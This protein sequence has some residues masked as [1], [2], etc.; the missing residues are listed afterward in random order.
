MNEQTRRTQEERRDESEQRML[1]AGIRLVAEFGPEKLTLTEVG[2]SAGYSR[3]LPA[4]H[5]GSREQYLKALASHVAIEFDRTLS[6][7]DGVTGL[8]AVLDITRAVVAQLEADPT[9]GLATR[10]VLADARRERALSE[11]IAELRDGTLALLTR[12]I[13]AGIAAGEIRPDVAP[14]TASLLIATGICGIIETW[15]AQPGFDIR[16]AGDQLLG[17]IEH[18]LKA[19]DQPGKPLAGTRA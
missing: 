4:H 1:A 3:G 18:G 9:G 2:K 12:H 8:G 17:L 7:A 10:I 11:D 14:G 16:G 5:F 19:P 6:S 15:L 13:E